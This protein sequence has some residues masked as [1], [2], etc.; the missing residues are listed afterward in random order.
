MKFYE[1]LLLILPQHESEGQMISNY[2]FHD[3]LA[4]ESHFDV[5]NVGK[6]L[7]EH[8]M[9]VHELPS[10][11]PPFDATWWETSVANKY[12]RRTGAASYRTSYGD[13]ITYAISDEDYSEKILGAM[14]DEIYWTVWIDVP[15]SPTWRGG[16]SVLPAAYIGMPIDELGR[17]I[18]DDDGEIA[19]RDLYSNPLLHNSNHPDSYARLMEMEQSGK[20]K[21]G[22]VR[23]FR[24]SKARMGV[25]YVWPFLVAAGFSH[26][27]NVEIV[28]APEVPYKIRRKRE[29][30][31]GRPVVQFRELVID[32]SM[33][34]KRYEGGSGQP[35]QRGTKSLHIARGHFATYSADRPLFG[36]YSG[37]FWK[38]AHVRGSAEVGM[39]GKD[40]AVKAPK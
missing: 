24:K 38:P 36:K 23:D 8:E 33:T 5:S 25:K 17:P 28:D 37:T 11:R 9:S 13:G 19:A 18:L 2:N 39:V 35:R 10:V 3:M 40:Y 30:K 14:R 15:P 29:L 6:Y 12:G 32:P 27:K 34:Q 20:V 21:P 4:A 22:A 16:I 26:C 7:R 1:D 31:L